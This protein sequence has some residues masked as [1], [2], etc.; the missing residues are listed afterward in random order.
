[1]T[2]MELPD[3]AVLK[4]LDGRKVAVGAGLG[5]GVFFLWKHVHASK[6]AP[7]AAAGSTSA[8]AGA[9][10]AADTAPSNY[11]AGGTGSGGSLIDPSSPSYDP[12]YAQY[13]AAQ[14]N[15]PVYDAAAAA[16]AA[17]AAAT[18]A[19]TVVP[20]SAPVI[21]AHAALTGIP[22]SVKAG[23]TQAQIAKQFGISVHDLQQANPVIQTPGSKVST[24][25]TLAIPYQPTKK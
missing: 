25:M 10:V 18:P 9:D 20:T 21:A 6:A 14:Y 2:G 11:A 15:P 22:Y 1:M 12:A 24:G 23:Q 5:L 7:A 13:Q 4:G 8:D 19:S 3:L 16:A 17:N